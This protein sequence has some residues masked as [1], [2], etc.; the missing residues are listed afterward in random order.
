MKVNTLT[1]C[2][3]IGTQNLFQNHRGQHNVG[4]IPIVDRGTP[5]KDIKT[6]LNCSLSNNNIPLFLKENGPKTIGTCLNETV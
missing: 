4:L 1:G 3:L 5:I 2:Q 6:C